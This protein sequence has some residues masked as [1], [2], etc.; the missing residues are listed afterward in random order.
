MKKTTITELMV[1]EEE[2]P[3]K[4][5]FRSS[6]KVVVGDW[7]GRCFILNISFQNRTCI[8]FVIMAHLCKHKLVH[9]MTIDEYC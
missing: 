6:L 1:L 3:N 8:I 7:T 4:S 9:A 5:P 2:N